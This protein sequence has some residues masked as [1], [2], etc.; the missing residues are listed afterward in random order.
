MSTIPTHSARASA[1]TRRRS[2]SAPRAAYRNEVKTRLRDD[3]YC[4]LQDFK[5]AHFIESDSA[6]L[7]RLVEILLCG[8]VRSPQTSVS[9]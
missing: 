4:R 7:A 3:V 6:A 8:I 2:A 1:P 5:Q 9:D